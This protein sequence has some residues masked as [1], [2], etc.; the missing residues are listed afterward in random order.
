MGVF[1]LTARKLGGAFLDRQFELRVLGASEIVVLRQQ[2]LHRGP[3]GQID[4][5]VEHDLSV[6]DVSP[7]S[8]H[9]G[10]HSTGPGTS[11]VDGSLLRRSNLGADVQLRRRSHAST[12]VTFHA[13][14]PLE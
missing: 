12:C 3:L 8:L 5:L 10:Q 11:A 4:R 14:T 1:E 7:Q 13:L 6:L 2:H 9:I